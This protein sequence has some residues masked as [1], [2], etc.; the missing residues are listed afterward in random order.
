[1][2]T[3][4]WMF[5]FS[6]IRHDALAGIWPQCDDRVTLIGCDF[7]VTE[8]GSGELFCMF[9][10]SR[11]TATGRPRPAATADCRLQA[12]RACITA[13]RTMAG[14]VVPSPAPV[15]A[16]PLRSVQYLRAAREGIK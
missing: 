16:G 13:S 14:S 10:A 11:P 12:D 1:M 2:H 5:V 9:G 15:A 3:D 7:M 8:V 6:L 4:G